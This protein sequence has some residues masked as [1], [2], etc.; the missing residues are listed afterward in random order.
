MKARSIG[1]LNL[2][3]EVREKHGK[4]EDDKSVAGLQLGVFLIQSILRSRT[5]ATVVRGI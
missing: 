3:R 5:Q 1:K 4:N 2:H